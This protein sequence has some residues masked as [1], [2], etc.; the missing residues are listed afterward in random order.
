MLAESLSAVV[1]QQLLKT[2]DGKGRC[3][4]LEILIG[5][6]ALSNTIREGKISQINSLIQT[7]STSGMQ[8]M[9]QNLLQLIK[10]GRITAQ[11]ADEKAFDKKVF[12]NIIERD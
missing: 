10:E 7:G 1:A 6:P 8:S 3:A 9:D 12:E 11:A 5:S 2:K 4:A